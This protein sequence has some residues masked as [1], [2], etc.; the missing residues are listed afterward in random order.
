M[1][2][3]Q[4]IQTPQVLELPCNW[5]LN[6]YDASD[7]E[8]DNMAIGYNAMTTNTAGG[9]SNIAIGNYAGDAITSGDSNCALGHTA[10]GKVT[11]VSANTGIGNN[12]LNNLVNGQNNT[13]LGFQ[14]G[15]ALR[16]FETPPAITSVLVTVY[17][18]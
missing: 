2:S 10:L 15:N 13:G 17:V 16:V 4:D 6:A 7:T 11:T 1:A 8:N 9:E 3:K 5:L 14:T 12:A 18:A